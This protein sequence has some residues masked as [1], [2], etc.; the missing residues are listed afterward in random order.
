MKGKV[1]VFL[2][3]FVVLT[4]WFLVN[5]DV[6]LPNKVTG[7][8]SARFGNATINFTAIEN[9]LYTPVDAFTSTFTII[10]NVSGVL[11]N[12]SN[13]SSIEL[14]SFYNASG[15]LRVEFTGFFPVGDVNLTDMRIRV[16]DGRIAVNHEN[17]TNTGNKTLYLDNTQSAGV[18]VCPNA[19]AVSQVTPSCLNVIT[20]SF[21]EAQAGT[22]KSGITV[23]LANASTYKI[24]NL[25]GSGAG[26]L[27]VDPWDQIIEPEG[28][29]QADN[30]SFTGTNENTFSIRFVNL[31]LAPSDILDCRVKRSDG[32]IISV[33]VTGV[34]LSDANY[35]LN[36]TITIADPV[37]RNAQAGYIPW[38]LKNCSLIR[39]TSL[40][41]VEQKPRRIYVHP[42]TFWDDSEITRAVAC[43]GTPGVYFNNTAKCEFTEDTVFSLQMRN[44][45]PVNAVCLNNPG[46]GCGDPLCNGIF[47]PTCD[48]LVFFPGFNIS[49]DDP[50][51]FTEFTS[52]FGSYNTPVDYTL[53]TNASSGNFKLRIRQPLSSKTFSVTVFN[54]SNVSSANV[55]GQNTGG[56]T[57]SVSPQPDGSYSVALNRLGTPFTGTLDFTFN[58]SFSTSVNDN[59]TLKL[60]IAYGT[61]TNQGSPDFFPAVFNDTIGFT[62]ND[63]GESTA[64][65]TDL[66]GVCGDDVN[67]DF[68][69]LGGTFANSYDCFDS[70]CDN[71]PGGANQTNEFGTGFNGLC[72]FAVEGNCNDTY[73]NDYDYRLGTDFTDCHDAD[74]FQ[75]GV[76][77]PAT[78]PICNN[79]FND[80]W[81]YT[82]GESD[83]SADQKI[84]NSGTKYSNTNKADITDCEDPDCDNQPGG[85]A[86]QLCNWGYEANCSDGFDNDVL[87][88]R[89]C[90]LNAVA[91]TKTFVTPAYAE[92]DCAGFCR[93]NF[94]STETGALCDDNID[95]DWDA[96]VVTGFFSNTFTQNTASGAG[97]DCRWSG[98][99]GRGTDY[100]PDEDC[101]GTILSSGFV[102]QLDRELNCSDGFDND[103]D[104]DS[105]NMPHANWGNDPAGYLSTFGTAF[106]NDADLDDYDCAALAPAS[107]SS[108]VSWCFDG[109]DN[110]LDAFVFNGAAYVSNA[111]GGVDCA[112]PDCVG[113]TNPDNSS[114]A[115]LA[116]EYDPADTFFT[117]LPFPGIFCSNSL[118]DDV[119]GL[120]D[121]ADSDCFK[122]FDGCSQGPCYDVENIIWDSCA[123]GVDNDFA[124]GTDCADAD[125]IGFL[126]S[127][128]GPLCEATE[129]T[130]DDNFDN[131]AQGG[132]DCLD[133]D[134]VGSVGGS[135]NN[136]DVFCR[137]SESTL[138]DCFD[139]FDNDADNNLDCMDIGCNA[140]CNLTNIA[141]SSPIT[142]PHFSGQIYL[143][144]V[145]PST[146]ARIDD[147]TDQVRR[148]ESYNITFKGIAASSSAQWTLGTGLGGKFD[149]SVFDVGSAS[150]SGP[151]AGSFSLTQTVNGWIVQSTAALPAGYSVTFNIKSTAT[152]P[153]STYELTYA[154][155]TGSLTSLNNDI[156]YFIA[157]NVSPTA[158]TLAVVPLNTALGIGSP[159]RIRANISDNNALGLCDFNVSGAASFNP[160]D[161]TSCTGSF[162]PSVEGVYN[163]SVIPVDFYSNVGQPLS[164]LYSLNLRPSSNTSS[165]SSRF[166]QPGNVN[167]TSTFIL[168]AADSL[169][170]CEA[171]AQ[172]STATVSLGNFAPAGNTCS[173]TLDVSGLSDGVYSLFFKATEATEG[174]VVE[175]ASESLFVCSQTDSGICR[176]ADFNN[177]NRAD[178]CPLES[179]TPY[180]NVSKVDSEDPLLSGSQ[181]NYTIT[182]ANAGRGNLTNVTVIDTYDG[183]TVFVSSSPPPSVGDDTFVFP[184]IANGTVVKINLTVNVKS[185]VGGGTTLTNTLGVTAINETGET[186]SLAASEDTVFG[187]APV[188][189]VGGGGGAGAGARKPI[190]LREEFAME[191]DEIISPELQRLDSILFELDGEIHLITIIKV[192]L[193]SVVVRIDS[194]EPHE[195]AVYRGIKKP[196]DIDRDGVY[197]ISLEIVELNAPYV[198]LRIAKLRPDKV[199]PVSETEAGPE[200][201][202]KHAVK[203]G[204]GKT[205][206]AE[207]IEGVSE[208]AEKPGVPARPS[209]LLL[210]L[211]LLLLLIVLVLYGMFRGRRKRKRGKF[212]EEV[213]S[214]SRRIEEMN[215]LLKKR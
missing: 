129:T 55:Y 70:D 7:F 32:S 178:S 24:E 199:V 79:S 13:S 116:K 33:N 25:P 31:S 140:V 211:A 201:S 14:L 168:T 151:D 193:D 42:P 202:V 3:I 74:C 80:D 190:Q 100:N 141:G 155:A 2:L 44:G 147:S 82:L 73:D 12:G 58:V 184:V 173:A 159:V 90:Q 43:E 176:F 109:I 124:D 97:I 36:R 172:N 50:N 152:K 17:V 160:A 205:E 94:T 121:C 123:D 186:L 197:D 38:V 53:Y 84:L 164:T 99:A 114:E 93:A 57:V 77:C 30:A 179:L 195:L 110:D 187:R 204:R 48:P 29:F 207:S 66:N 196:V 148:G 198:I 163:I 71:L 169:N 215:K 153:A 113:L 27:T 212:E 175:G 104:A 37:V 63:E 167:L 101:N 88:L 89:D 203:G 5:S 119:D 132:I 200:I 68:D 83:N 122:Q 69:Y 45:N 28:V 21:S 64:I 145:N 34:A 59:R 20:F 10:G 126:G 213:Q 8:S 125:C 16:G 52:S 22:T 156:D 146:E 206:V 103:F 138:A 62:N 158:D 131:D 136:N 209:S 111:G 143:N 181:L 139:G 106:S 92:Y 149:N 189:S 61:E 130:C 210:A 6:T 171:F 214:I 118:D 192:R 9:T 180:L 41:F 142:L 157:E 128:S 166:V 26:E 182:L 107:E 76:E 91:G 65:A 23:S 170:N 46:A 67:N 60:V 135:I 112:D 56:G 39:N 134:C 72:T 95:N 150:L 208:K 40:A 108:N 96:V 75:N 35:S 19:T 49:I 1:N 194:D 18:F 87:Q 174:D 11:V 185:G 51:G 165:I 15:A 4:A 188:P 137:A 162:T 115:C 78:E 81:D 54:L 98:F 191:I 120:V 105:S 177:D 86:G 117:S 154:E 161:S 144:A 85:P 183:S 47:F 127:T 133:S 102:C